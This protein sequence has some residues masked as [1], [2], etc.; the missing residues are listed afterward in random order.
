MQL[1]LIST[2]LPNFSAFDSAIKVDETRPRR[3][4]NAF[5]DAQIAL[6]FDR[7]AGFRKDHIWEPTVNVKRFFRRKKFQVYFPIKDDRSSS[8]WQ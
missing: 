8:S 1:T 7:K 4:Y 5:L 2:Y 6:W 3:L